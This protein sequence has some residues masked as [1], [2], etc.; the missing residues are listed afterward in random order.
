MNESVRIL[1]H[2]KD[3][4]K[5]NPASTVDS[6]NYHQNQ[7]NIWKQ[8]TLENGN[9]T[10]KSGELTNYGKKVKDKYTVIKPNNK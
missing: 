9:L 7:T 4:K 1:K 6:E 8:K 3:P 5:E 10:S 2:K